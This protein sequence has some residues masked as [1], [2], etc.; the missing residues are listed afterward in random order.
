MTDKVQVEIKAP[1][2]TI[3]L[4]KPERLNA[5]DFEMW[6]GIGE[7]CR[8]VDAAP[9]VRVAVLMGAGGCF[10]AGLDVKAGSTL[11]QLGLD[12]SPGK[13]LPVIRE[14]L[15]RLQDCFTAVEAL[16]MPVIAAIQRACMGAGVELAVC[17]DIRVAAEG[18]VF[19]IPEVQLGI[20]PD[21]GGTQRLPR[22]IGI[23]YAKELIYSARRID[24]AEA[25][26]IGLV[27]HVYPAGELQAR[28]AELAAEIAANAP[29]AVQA[30]KQSIDGTYWRDRQAWLDWEAAQAAGP[31]LSE[32]RKEGMKAAAERTRANF[33]GK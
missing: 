16:R 19:S 29:L 12:A 9:D 32:D 30:A 11:N 23:G 24:A 20:V 31:L 3:T 13:A 22:T 15:S 25:L 28:V 18:T 10:C 5:L 4:N 21:M 2:A 14:H 33:Q 1:V 17:C 8:A 26:R 27:N 6:E 7:A